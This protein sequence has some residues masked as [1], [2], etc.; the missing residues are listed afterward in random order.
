MSDDDQVS[1]MFGLWEGEEELFATGWTDAGTARGVISVA[2]GP[3]G[4]LILDYSED[5]DGATMTG[6][7]VVFASKWWWFD[8]YGFTP[9]AP[10]TAEWRDD[11]LVLVRRSERGRTVTVLRI[12]DG[13]LEQ[14]I[15]TA[16]PA[17]GPLVP[18]LRGSY[19]RTDAQ[20]V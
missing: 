16:M 9:T 19:L 1:A 11:E 13:R 5:R 3:G 8:S 12:R 10:G 15:D 14:D 17:G 2:A 20:A 7:G 4:G 18:L 6:H